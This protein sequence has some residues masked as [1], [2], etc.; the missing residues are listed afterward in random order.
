MQSFMSHASARGA[1]STAL[2][3]LQWALGLLLAAIP[4]TLLAAAPGWLVGFLVVA[5]GIVLTV[6]LGA[7][8]FLLLRNPDA[9][10][11][12]E[13]SLNKMALEKG[14]IGDST[15]GFIDPRAIPLGAHSN[16]LTIATN[17]GENKP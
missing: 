14:L 6:F 4:I 11:S 12:E 16:A 8:I 17:Q 15:H 13:F 3:A 7:Y 5:V 9:L 10:R 2:H 1:R